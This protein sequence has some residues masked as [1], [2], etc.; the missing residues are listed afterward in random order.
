MYKDKERQREADKAR[1]KRRRDKIKAKGVTKVGVT[2]GVTSIEAKLKAVVKTKG[3]QQ[4]YYGPVFT[5]R[6][7][8]FEREHYKPAGE[9]GPGKYNPVS[10]PGDDH[11]DGVCL[12]AK[13]DGRR[14]PQSQQE[15]HTGVK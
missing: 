8:G 12:D 2:Q 9:L 11:Y 5:G 10:L 6:M 14:I 13:Y 7:T 3:E 15:A 4:M 1:Q